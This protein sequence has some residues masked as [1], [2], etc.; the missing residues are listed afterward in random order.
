M[1]HTVHAH[2]LATAVLTAAT[3]A[4][5]GCGSGAQRDPAATFNTDY[6]AQS[7]DLKAIGDQI[8]A[9]IRGADRQTDAQVAASFGAI[10]TRAHAGADALAG[11]TPPGHAAS[12]LAALKA[13]VDKAAG[14][15]D[16]ITAA[17]RAGDAAAATKA[18]QALVTDSIPI[19]DARAALDRVVRP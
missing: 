6:A 4:V 5:S 7:A 10:A 8:L 12:Q 14:D 17:A 1:T 2:A 15:L 19:R 18:S 3:L 13:A 9:A 11:L 16:A